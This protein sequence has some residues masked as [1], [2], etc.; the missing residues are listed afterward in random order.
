MVVAAVEGTVAEEEEGGAAET[1]GPG[2]GERAY[3]Q[4]FCFKDGCDLG[5]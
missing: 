5:R 2:I 1:S 3:Q 4:A